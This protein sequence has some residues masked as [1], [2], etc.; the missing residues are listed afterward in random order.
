[1][2][3]SQSYALFIQE[4]LSIIGSISLKK[5][6]GEYGVFYCE[7]MVGLICDDQL[8][9]KPTKIG[10]EILV[11]PMMGAPYPGAKPYF[12][13]ENPENRELLSKLILMTYD[14][15]PVPKPKKKKPKVYTIV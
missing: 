3:T 15:L 4:Q 10:Q 13:I 6:F 11:D 5:M 1:M 12:V 14:E 2:A 7:K 8:F 9:I